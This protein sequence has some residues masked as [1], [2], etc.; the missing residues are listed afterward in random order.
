MADSSAFD[1]GRAFGSLQLSELS[2]LGSII[3]PW[4][5]VHGHQRYCEEECE[6]HDP[7]GT[8]ESIGYLIQAVEVSRHRLQRLNQ[9]AAKFCEPVWLQ[10]ALACASSPCH[11]YESPC[12]FIHNRITDERLQ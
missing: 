9:V 4:V 10:C 11:S 2:I 7:S 12:A 6:E 3:S 5:K 1:P 8:R